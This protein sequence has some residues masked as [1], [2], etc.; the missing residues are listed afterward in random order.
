M[1]TKTF[2]FEWTKPPLSLNYRMHRMQE[3]KIVKEVRTLMHASARHMP[4]LGRCEVRLVWFVKDRR[5]RDDENPVS[6]LKAL[7]DGLVDA[8][9][10]P[11]DTHEYMV[12]HMPEIRYVP[13]CTPHFEF[14]VTEIP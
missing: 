13:G 8:E 6:T 11:D 2:E 5:R 12:K 1:F 9:V 4:D 10:V 14:T 3:A 7:C